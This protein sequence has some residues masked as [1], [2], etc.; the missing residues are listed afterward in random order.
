M[1]LVG[2]GPPHGLGDGRRRRF[3][4]TSVL[5]RG[6]VRAHEVTGVSSVGNSGALVG[7]ESVKRRRNR[8]RRDK[9]GR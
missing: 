9:G 1:G 3:G 4:D 8:A 2:S 7:T 5:R 6:V